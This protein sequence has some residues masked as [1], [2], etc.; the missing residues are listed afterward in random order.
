MAQHQNTTMMVPAP[1]SNSAS[2]NTTTTRVYGV[3]MEVLS[4]CLKQWHQHQQQQWHINKK[5]SSTSN[6][7]NKNSDD[8][9]QQEQQEQEQEQQQQQQQNHKINNKNSAEMM[10]MDQ[11]CIIP[12]FNQAASCKALS[13]KQPQKRAQKQQQ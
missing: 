12:D 2:T 5:L 9:Q 7:I 1:K 10:R 11:V 3:T 4:K 13:A 6:N 8:S